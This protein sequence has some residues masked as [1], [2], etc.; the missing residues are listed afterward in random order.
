[1]TTASYD[2]T[3]SA[4]HAVAESLLAGPQHRRSGT[5]RLTV[6]DGGFSTL[7]IEGDV[8]RIAVE[9]SDLVVDTTAGERRS[10]LRGTLG[11]L[12]NEVGLDLGPPQGVYT[13]VD[14]QDATTVIVVDPD[15]VA[16]VLRSLARGDAALRRVGALEVGGSGPQPVLWPEHFDVGITIDEV[17]LGVS[18]GDGL[19]AEPYA[20]VGPRQPRRGAFWNQ[21]FGA[22]RPLA[23]LPDAEA[24]ADWFALGL[25]AARI[26]PLT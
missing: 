7:P 1:M 19:V 8:R 26:D 18:P 24:V 12:A 21:P 11:G 16:T 15:D 13:V 3:R 9:G 17:N 10:P 20:Y 25:A 2:E 6:T 5:I 14:E 4:L 23:S 22:A